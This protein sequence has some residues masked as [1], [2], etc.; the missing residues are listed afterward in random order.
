MRDHTVQVVASI[1]N[2][3]ARL[4]IGK[5]E[6]RKAECCGHERGLR[7]RTSD[8]YL[9][10]IAR[11]SETPGAHAPFH[12]S[13]IKRMFWGGYPSLLLTH[14][15]EIVDDLDSE[16]IGVHLPNRGAHEHSL[17]KPK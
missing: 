1:T 4:S 5:R 2:A 12:G 9:R 11:Y 15:D 10:S 17:R 3:S 7:M 8:A 16:Y 6:V 14:T 13:A